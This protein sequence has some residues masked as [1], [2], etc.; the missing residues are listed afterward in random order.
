MDPFKKITEENKIQLLRRLEA[1]TLTF[2][3]NESILQ[4]IKTDD[5]FGIVVEGNIQI[6]K[7]DYNG[8]RTII[9]ELNRND[10]FGSKISS[11][12]INECEIITKSLSKIIILDYYN[13]VNYIH[14]E[15]DV[16]HQFVMNLFEITVNIVTEKNQRINIL[17]KN[18][19]RNKLLEYF[20]I[21]SKKTDS[22]TVYLPFSFTDLS[23]YLA[24]DRS[25][26]SREIKHLKDEN[27]ISVKGR[28]I[29]LLYK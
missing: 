24:I 13:I 12:N 14:S 2:Q 7:T 16:Y 15:D 18:T 19:I 23:D 1:T 29:R 26:M 25:A 6:I 27:I 8:N 28:K 22:R 20:D 3:K 4:N 11:Y 10:I 9:E 17:T 5:I 21:A